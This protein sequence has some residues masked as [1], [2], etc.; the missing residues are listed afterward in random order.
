ML[1]RSNSHDQVW[2][3]DAYLYNQDKIKVDDEC[4]IFQTIAFSHE[5]EWEKIENRFRNKATNTLP[6]FFHGNGHTNMNWL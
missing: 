3:M 2:L 1:F 6:V 4:K 5:N